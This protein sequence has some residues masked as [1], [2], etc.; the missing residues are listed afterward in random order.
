MRPISILNATFSLISAMISA[1]SFVVVLSNLS[2][3]APLVI[4]CAALPGAIVNIIYRNR[5]FRYIRFHSKERRQMQYYS[6]L[7]VDKDRVQEVKILGLSDTFIAKYKAAFA[8]YY[9][10]L[11]SLIVK[12]GVTQ[13]GVSLVS[14]HKVQL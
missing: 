7:L 2:A 14:P 6:S 13:I 12:E 9:K 11:K 10:G 4:L 5:N 8:K 1:I 3:Y